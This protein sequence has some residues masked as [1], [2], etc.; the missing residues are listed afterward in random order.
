MFSSICGIRVFQGMGMI[1]GFCAI[2]QAGAIRGGC[3]QAA[4]SWMRSTASGASV[5]ALAS[6]GLHLRFQ[7]GV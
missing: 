3:D 6:F 7:A 5:L 4:R 1:K 2:S